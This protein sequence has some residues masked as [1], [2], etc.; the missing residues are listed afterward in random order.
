MTGKKQEQLADVFKAVATRLYANTVDADWLNDALDPMIYA[1]P[2][3]AKYVRA[4]ST[5][6]YKG[7]TDQE[8]EE[9]VK[10]LDSIRLEAAYAIAAHLENKLYT[11]IAALF[12][13][14]KNLQPF[15]RKAVRAAKKWRAELADEK[16]QG[17]TTKTTLPAQLMKQ[18]D[19]MVVPF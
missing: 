4:A 12:K 2:V 8:C 11:E 13:N 17:T 19:E 14:E 16:T 10:A 7:C 15:V 5:C 1:I 6:T 18:L 3:Q 9:C